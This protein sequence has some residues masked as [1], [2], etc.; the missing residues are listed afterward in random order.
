MICNQVLTHPFFLNADTVYCY[1]DYRAEVATASIIKKAWECGKKVAVPRVEGDELRFY[2]IQS[3]SD[4][5]EGYKGILEPREIHPADAQTALVLVPGVA[6][7]RECKRIGYGKGF[8]DRFLSAHTHYRTMA[9]AFELQIVDK[10][11]ADEHDICP[12]I[13]VTEEN[14]YVRNIAK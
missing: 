12:Q 7:D 6:F 2:Y 8:Y 4:L 10:I 9:L 1:V 14:Y 13:V 3:F 11:P 5:V